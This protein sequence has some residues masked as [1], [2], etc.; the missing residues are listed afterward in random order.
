MTVDALR[1]KRQQRT[2][3]AFATEESPG[4]MLGLRSAIDLA[5]AFTEHI[6]SRVARQ[7][8]TARGGHDLRL[9]EESGSSQGLVS[10]FALIDM[11]PFP[12]FCPRTLAQ[13]RLSTGVQRAGQSGGLPNCSPAV[14][15]ARI[16]MVQNSAGPDMQG[17][18]ASVWFVLATF[19]QPKL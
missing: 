1:N 12:Q 6:N 13:D 14:V 16:A 18:I 8:A 2:H 9:E 10:G 4:C 19:D 7:V 3:N 15:I 11:W 17:K 5:Q